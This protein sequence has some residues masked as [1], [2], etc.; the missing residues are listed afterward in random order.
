MPRRHKY[1]QID[2]FVCRDRIYAGE[3]TFTPYAGFYKGEGQRVLGELLD[4][5]R[6]TFREP[7]A[8]N[9]SGRRVA[10]Q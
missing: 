5:D 7:L 4:F 10:V 6:A 8:A 1:V 2:M 3:I 9:H